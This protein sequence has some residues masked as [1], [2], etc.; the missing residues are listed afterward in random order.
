MKPSF[1]AKQNDWGSISPPRMP[2]MNHLTKFNRS[3]LQSLWTEVVLYVWSYC[4]FWMGLLDGELSRVCKLSAFTQH[5]LQELFSIYVLRNGQRDYHIIDVLSD[6]Q[7]R[8]TRWMGL[9]VKSADGN[10]L[11]TIDIQNTDPSRNCKQPVD[12]TN[13]LTKQLTTAPILL[14]SI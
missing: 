9:Y 3:V 10:L 12:V 8:E 13:I 4:A 5:F 11:V 7:R 1:V 2:R 6:K 14:V